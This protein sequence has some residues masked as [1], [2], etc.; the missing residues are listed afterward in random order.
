LRPSSS[1]HAALSA[2]AAVLLIAG[3]PGIAA[4][5]PRPSAPANAT[6][7]ADIGPT[8][9]P[10]PATLLLLLVDLD[11]V[12]LT[13]GLAAYGDP[14][15]PLIPV[16]EFS[17]LLELDIDIL[18]SERRMVGRLG[19][20]RRSLV[21]DL[22]TSTA[23]VGAA[24]I[25]LMADDIAVTPNEIYLRATALQ[26]L[27][28]IK[29]DI[30]P[31][32]LTMKVIT[33]ELLPIQSRMQR[34]ARQRLGSPTPNAVT[35]T[36][37][38][39]APYQIFTP[40]SFDIA[41]ALGAQADT[42]RNPA[43]YDIRLGGDLAYMGLQAYVGSDEQGRAS[44]TR[45]LLERRSMDATLLGPLRATSFGLGDVFTP[46]LAIGPRSLGGRGVVVSNAP[47]DQA[48]VFNRIDLRGELPL[49]NDVELYVN[50]V[51]KG[52][53]TAADQGRYEFLN[54]PLVPG[55]NIIRIVTYGPRGQRSEEAR[56]I[57]VSGGLLRPGQA[58]FEFG[59]MEQDQ[60][61]FRVRDR[62]PFATDRSVGMPRIIASVNYG[63]TQYLT[64]SGGAALYHTRQGAEQN[65]YTAG[66]RTTLGGFATQVDVARDSEGGRALSFA[67]AGRI[68]G[69]SAVLR[70]AEYGGGLIDEVNPA[71]DPDRPLDRRTEL[72]VDQNIAIA[73][74]LVP[75][76]LRALRD[77]Y[78]DG[79]EALIGS[80]RG[81]SAIGAVLFS[82]GLEYERDTLI[83]G[84]RDERLRGYLAASTFRNYRWQIRA[85]IDYDIIPTYRARLLTVTADRTLSDIWTI[86]LAASQRLDAPRG[87][88]FIAGSITRTR[89]GD[90]ALTG[91]Y[92]T[93][94]DSWRL[95]MQLNFGLGYNPMTQRY[96]MTRS[97]P[98]SGGAVLFHAFID[99]NGDGRFEPGERP[100][101]NLT[102]EGGERLMRTDADGQAYITGFGA[103][104][105]A[106]LQV[107]L[108][109]IE[110]PSVKAP[111]TTIEFSPRPGGVT[112][113]SY[114]IRATGEVMVNIKLRRPDAQ[115]V[116]LSAARVRLVDARGL[117]VEGVTE[118]DGSVS[119][120]DM[121]GGPYRLE[122]DAEQ[123]RR[124][125][126]RLTDPVS[127]TIRTDGFT[128]DVTAEVVFEP[129]PGATPD[130]P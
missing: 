50:D 64:L 20:A 73:G 86:R 13:E 9:A 128:P 112:E 56:V 118:F 45:V 100:V 107:G 113:I 76:S 127:I 90:L 120:Q 111:P 80:A 70:H 87:S 3:I 110:E 30:N 106:R 89:F 52:S 101:R 114:P 25:P 95:G 54:V 93:A 11:G 32:Q 36:L 104:N 97:G 31:Q 96:E 37:R 33:Y 82:T 38:V 71:A 2:I 48:S 47:L 46:A 7:A 18:P 72:T 83:N 116:G 15:D 34:Q 74:H 53:Q 105:T 10:D 126:M 99:E 23:R 43:R 60:P 66:L 108:A 103:A 62:D 119:F 121:P 67:V 14:A 44:T 51:L 17:R 115:S 85:N 88:E 12:T 63:V 98:G 68:L 61:L 81:S 8:P 78:S 91:E 102:L 109:D 40:P 49:G 57:N 6:P 42:P 41:L 77:V 29:L 75:I 21:V 19:E 94:D 26:K 123:S 28:P 27:L 129:R 69:A 35:E 16:G 117:A 59:A 122:L 130:I 4:A 58:T 55:V 39:E 92:D 125:R 22:A 1:R 5:Q 84:S 65:L 79:G 124:L 24:E